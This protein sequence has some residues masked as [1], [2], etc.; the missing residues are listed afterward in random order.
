MFIVKNREVLDFLG[1]LIIELPPNIFTLRILIEFGRVYSLHL[2]FEGGFFCVQVRKERHLIAPEIVLIY[3]AIAHKVSRVAFLAVGGGNLEV[4][5]D[6]LDCFELESIPLLVEAVIGLFSVVA[7]VE[8]I[9]VRNQ[10]H[11]L[12]PINLESKGSA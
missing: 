7:V 2:V 12:L 1:E 4:F 6:V 3:E 9:C 5:W 10:A 11:G 8:H